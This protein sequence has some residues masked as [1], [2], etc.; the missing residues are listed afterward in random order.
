VDALAQQKEDP[1]QGQRPQTQEM[2]LL[3]L[4]HACKC[5]VVVSTTARGTDLSRWLLRL[6]MPSLD[7]SKHIREGQAVGSRAAKPGRSQGTLR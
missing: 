3:L 2:P 1:A 7:G 4:K 5:C 6:S